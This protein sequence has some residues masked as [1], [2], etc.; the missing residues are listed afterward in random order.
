MGSFCR[1]Y[2][3][4]GE[5]KYPRTAAFIGVGREP[6]VTKAARNCRFQMRLPPEGARA[7]FGAVGSR[8]LVDSRSGFCCVCGTPP[9]AKRRS[10]QDSAGIHTISYCSYRQC[11]PQGGRASA[12]KS[13]DCGGFAAAAHFASQ[14]ALRALAQTRAVG[15]I[16]ALRY[17]IMTLTHITEACGFG[18]IGII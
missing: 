4:S 17:G 15:L 13:A 8:P 11:S 3:G 1:T 7:S 10:S 12:D 16:F 6:R 18:K 5:E 2:V 9:T 14:N